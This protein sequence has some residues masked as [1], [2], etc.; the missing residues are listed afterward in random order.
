MAGSLRRRRFLHADQTDIDVLPAGRLMAVDRDVVVSGT[1]C[2][3]RRGA[4]SATVR[5]IS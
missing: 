4:D 3:E 2:L 1:Q 5:L